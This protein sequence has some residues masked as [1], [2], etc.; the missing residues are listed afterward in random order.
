MKSAI[1][2]SLGLLGFATA[3]PATEVERT[4]PA[5]WEYKIAS[6]RGPGCPDFGADPEKAFATRLTYGQNTMDGSEIYYWFIAYPHLHVDLADNDSSWCETEISYEEYSNYADKTPSADYRL[7]LHKNGTRAIATYDLEKGVK[8]T[9][10]FEYDAGKGE[11]YTDVINWNG[12]AASGQYQQESSSAVA[13]DE[14]YKLP[15]CGAGKIKFRTELSIEGKKGQKG[16]VASETHEFTKGKVEYYGI[17]QGFSYD[18]EKC[19]K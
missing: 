3:L 8:A 4:L 10:K 6:L 13:K 9:I 5:G 17:Q 18:W 15:K 11:E 1:I 14:L 12:P 2:T 7:R 19:K 16:F